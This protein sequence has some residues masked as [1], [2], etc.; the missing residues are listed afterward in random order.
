MPAAET[1]VKGVPR[2]RGRGWLYILGVV[3]VGKGTG[4]YLV[5]GKEVAPCAHPRAQLQSLC[6]PRQAGVAGAPTQPVVEVVLQIPIPQL[7]RLQD[8]IGVSREEVSIEV[9][10]HRHQVKL[11]HTPDLQSRLLPCLE[12]LGV[13][14]HH[15]A[16][17]GGDMAETEQ[18]LCRKQLGHEGGWLQHQESSLEPPALR[19]WDEPTLF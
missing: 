2:V 6:C 18:G 17:L 8:D 3:D 1:A 16:G 5:L 15:A 9:G 10:R 13:F 4:T 14:H 7:H 11:F 19:G 12:E